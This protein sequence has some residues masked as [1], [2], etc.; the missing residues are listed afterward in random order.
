[1]TTLENLPQQ[2]LVEVADALSPEERNGLIDF[3]AD[4]GMLYV[5]DACLHSAVKNNIVL[6]EDVLALLNADFRNPQWYR[7]PNRVRLI[8]QANA[9]EAA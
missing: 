1:M 3:L 2:M 6:S 8:E 9:L 7:A 5:V 4:G